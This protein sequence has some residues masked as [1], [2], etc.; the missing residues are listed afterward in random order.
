MAKQSLASFALTTHFTGNHLIEVDGDTA[1]TE[2][3]TRAT[4]RL[5]ADDKG[6]ERDYVASVRYIDRMECRDGEWRIA[7][8][9]CVLD[10]ARTDPVPEH[11]E[12]PKTG[13]A[14]RDRSDA[15]YLAE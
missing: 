9:Q 3:Y 15:C 13:T 11:C 10:W 14:R 8:R 12:G 2:F 6:P 4:H 1:C 5:V 7:R